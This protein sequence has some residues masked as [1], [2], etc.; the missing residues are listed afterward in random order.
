MAKLFIAQAVMTATYIY[1]LSCVGERLAMTMREDLFASILRQDVAFY[2]A[3]KSGEIMSRLTTD[4][5]EFK[6]SFKQVI[7]MGLRSMAQ[8][9]GSTISLYMIS[10]EMTGATL[11]VLPAVIGVGT[12][13]GAYLRSM[14]KEAQKQTAKASGVAD[15]CVSNIRTV[16]AFAMEDEE[17][18]R[19]KK[20]LDA[21]RRL[22]E[23]LGLGIGLFQGGVNLFLNGVV[24]GTLYYGGYLLSNQQVT[25]GDLMSFLVAT[26]T[27]QRSLGQ[28]SL[29]FGQM[30]KGMSAGGRVLEYTAM[31]PSIPMKGGDTIPFHSLFGDIEFQNVDFRYPTRP[32]Q[33]ILSNFSIKIPAGQMVALV[34]SSGGGKSTIAALVERFYDCDSGQITLDG[35]NLKTLDPSWLRGRAIGYI[36]QEPVLFANSILENIRYG[37]PSATNEEVIEAA[38][39]ANAHTFISGFPSGYSTILGERGVTLSGGQRQRI[40]IARAIVK[41]P[42]ILILDEA[43]SALDAESEKIVQEALDNVCKGKTVLVIAHRLST[44]R[45]ANM[46][47]VISG[48]KVVETGTHDQL[49]NKKE[50]IYSYLIRQQETAT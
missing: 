45:H 35:K 4:I 34:G 37:R 5:Q 41:Q 48:G 3:H 44:I 25:P 30:I 24:L 46:I 49:K 9:V 6:S 33:K 15:E 28:M 42:S 39:A 29:L 36:S 13:L 21:A 40:A 43:T 31:K 14:S 17:V 38:K 26:Q 20:E 2:D 23:R 47:A 16:R 7:S 11:L 32:D 10:P 50:G 8:T 12:F 18:Y 1:S 22:N 19:Y 27:I